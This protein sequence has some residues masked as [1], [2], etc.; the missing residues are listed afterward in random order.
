MSVSRIA[1]ATE[2][3]V[4]R[5]IHAEYRAGTTPEARDRRYARRPHVLEHREGAPE[6]VRG[7]W[8]RVLHGTRRADATRTR[9]HARHRETGAEGRETKRGEEGGG[10]GRKKTR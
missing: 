1:Y 10:G 6:P 8:A 2:N 9:A 4:Q 5:H 7:R 3:S